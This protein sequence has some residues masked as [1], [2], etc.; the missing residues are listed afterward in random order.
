MNYELFYKENIK[1]NVI[2]KTPLELNERLSRKYNCKVYLK[3]EDLQSVRS[4]KIRGAFNKII[5]SDIRNGIVCASA[6]NH[7]QGVALTCGKMNIKCDIF[8]PETTPTQKINRIKHFGN[9][10]CNLHIGGKTFDDCLINAKIFCEMRNATFVHPFDDMDIINGQSTIAHEIIEEIKPTKIVCSIGGGGLISGL[11][12]HKKYH[13]ERVEIYGAEPINAD[14]MTMA[15]HKKRP[16]QLCN[17][18]TFVDGAAVKKVGE[19]T[20]NICNGGASDI[21]IIPNGRIC[22]EIITLYQEDGIIAEPAG[23]MS[24]CALDQMA[25]DPGD[26]IVCIVSGGNNDILR[27]PEIVER[28]MIFLGIKH[29][30]LV[31]FGQK[32]GILKNYIS[33]VLNEYV[34]ITR[35]EY[36]K[37]SNKDLGNVLIGLEI[38]DV[39]QITIKEIEKKMK[40]M[41]YEYE[42]ITN[43][44]FAY[45]ML[46]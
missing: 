25:I 39:E 30:F 40:D 33:N 21:Y 29:Y 24:I 20:F 11:I 22:N 12:T 7:A 5:N 18:D 44:N 4:F 9:N 19:L 31:R 1:H 2:K 36:I 32:P 27:Y 26:T 41:D 37:K 14:S 6:G 17:I 42:Y 45:S 15:I 34:D 38:L 13:K 28:N 3:R 43:E 35:F 10:D 46:I 16:F 8:I 23:A